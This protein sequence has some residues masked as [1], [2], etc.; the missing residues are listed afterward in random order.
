MN[1]LI[2][3]WP[4]LTAALGIGLLGSLHCIGMCGPLA[5]IGCRSQFTVTRRFGPTMF[6]GA[7]FLSYSVLGLL[8]GL[9]G[10][11]VIGEGTVGNVTA[12]VSIVGGSLMILVIVLLRFAGYA[13]GKLVKISATISRF[14]LRSGKFAPL[15]LGVA[16]A[17]LPCGLLYAV[18]VKGAVTR[19]PILSMGI[20]Q[21]FSL[22]TS[23]AL[24]GVGTLMAMIPQKWKGFGNILAEVL[25]A[26][27][28]AIM[29]WR[30]IAGLMAG[31]AG[32]ACCP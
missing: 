5:M 4:E 19:D 23:P 29:I 7:K 20:L 2:E 8:A 24:I 26:V 6:V 10:S 13:K 22:G 16:A 12:W 18:V 3:H 14:A 15:F 32:P 11:A 9:L 28:G 25:L 21:A 1:T 30:G 17:L 27:T 31:E